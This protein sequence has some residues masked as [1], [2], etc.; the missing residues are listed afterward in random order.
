M[1]TGGP[2]ASNPRAGS[3][4]NLP[5]S[6]RTSP[7]PGWS[8]ISSGFSRLAFWLQGARPGHMTQQAVRR[9][10]HQS[11][12]VRAVASSLSWIGRLGGPA[13]WWRFHRRVPAANA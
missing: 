6:R 13:P 5:G 1:E 10:S 2:S 3:R 11:S 7:P 9:R 4:R 8:G 12:R